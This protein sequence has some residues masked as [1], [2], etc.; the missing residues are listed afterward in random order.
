MLLMHSIYADLALDAQ[1]EELE[2]VPVKDIITQSPAGGKRFQLAWRRQLRNKARLA[3]G[4]NAKKTTTWRDQTF[5]E[6][7]PVGKRTVA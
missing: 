6:N 7:A 2:Y 1:L 5:S 4:V 3:S